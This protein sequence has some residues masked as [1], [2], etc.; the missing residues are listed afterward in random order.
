[1]K[2]IFGIILSVIGSIIG[3][4]LKIKGQGEANGPTSIFIAGKIGGTS[5]I[6]GIFVGVILIIVGVSITVRKK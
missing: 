2:K 1:M 6:I 3:L 5:A 4:I